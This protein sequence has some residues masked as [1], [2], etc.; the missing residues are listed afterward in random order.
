M[1]RWCAL[2]LFTSALLQEGAFRFIGARGCGA[3]VAAHPLRRRGSCGLPRGI[4]LV[5]LQPFPQLLHLL[6][7]LLEHPLV[8]IN[9]SQKVLNLRG[10]VAHLL[11]ELFVTM[12]PFRLRPWLS[13]RQPR[14]D[15]I[16]LGPPMHISPWRWQRR[17]WWSKIMHVRG[18]QSQSKPAT[19][20]VVQELLAGIGTVTLSTALAQRASPR[21][22]HNS[23]WARSASWAAARRRA[24]FNFDISTSASKS[25][26]SR[27]RTHAS[28]AFTFM[29]SP[30]MRSCT[31]LSQIAITP[32]APDKFVCGP[33]V[34]SFSYDPSRTSQQHFFIL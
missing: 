19:K 3:G 31:L 11:A 7:L 18:I 5:S 16:N 10:E 29:E 28:P 9:H 32:L 21:R 12:A 6:G 13:L 4:A 2:L 23:S 15:C 17:R 24:V 34:V 33:L 30:S 26:L 25:S 1:F 20:E 22:Q 14:I 8:C 27:S